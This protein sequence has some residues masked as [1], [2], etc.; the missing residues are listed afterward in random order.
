MSGQ[1]SP[2]DVIKDGLLRLVAR[3]T[4]GSVRDP[5]RTPKEAMDSSLRGDTY[6]PFVVFKDKFTGKFVQFA[7]DQAEPLVLD[8]PTESLTSGEQARAAALFSALGLDSPGDTQLYDYPSANPSTIFHSYQLNFVLD[9]DAATTVTLRIFS[10][11]FLIPLDNLDV[12][13][14]EQ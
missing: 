1:S 5:S 11:L 2:Q 12:D 6:S 9:A 10:E 8:L 3:S 14:E 13:V 7:G 4:V